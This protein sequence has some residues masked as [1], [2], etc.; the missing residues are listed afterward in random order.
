MIKRIA[1]SYERQAHLVEELVSGVYLAIWR[2]I[3]LFS[4]GIFVAD[5]RGAYRHHRAVTHVARALRVPP[6]SNSARTSQRPATTRRARS[7]RSTARPD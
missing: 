6:S 2:D 4:R 7:L 3:A 1:L 5:I